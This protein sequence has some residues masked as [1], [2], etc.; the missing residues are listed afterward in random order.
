MTV[1][2]SVAE[3]VPPSVS[4]TMNVMVSVPVPALA[5]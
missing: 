1:T 5:T 3:L 2:V 4:C